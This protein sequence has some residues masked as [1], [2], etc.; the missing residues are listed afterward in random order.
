MIEQGYENLIL[1]SASP[2]RKT[3][4]KELGL[5]FEVIPADIDESF[6][7]DETALDY[8]R[9]LAFEK[10]NSLAQE[11]PDKIIVSADTIVVLHNEILGKPID[12]EDAFRILKTLSN[13]YHQV[14]T[15][16][17]ILS[18]KKNIKV[19]E[20]EITD[21]HFRELS[22]E[23]IWEYID[24]GSPMD[25]AGAYGI[26]DISAYLVDKIDGCYHNVMG[27]PVA[28]FAKKWMEIPSKQI[29]PC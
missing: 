22:D 24:T 7:E 13:N 14:I 2:R 19:L 3:L 4:L 11:H 27:F 18:I 16:F 9:R 21:V 15:S 1:A 17:A 23:D 26:Q 25:K 8:V 10:A 28:H 6:Q 20:H 12:K 29:H 5:K